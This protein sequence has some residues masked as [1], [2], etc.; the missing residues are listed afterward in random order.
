M[1]KLIL[2]PDK[3]NLKPHK[4]TSKFLIV[5]NV[6]FKCLEDTTSKIS[7]TA[8]ES[9]HSFFQLKMAPCLFTNYK[10]IYKL[11]YKAESLGFCFFNFVLKVALFTYQK[12]LIFFQTDSLLH[13][14]SERNSLLQCLR[15]NTSR[16]ASC[17]HGIQ[18]LQGRRSPALNSPDS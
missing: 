4:I 1:I 17:T 11:I 15:S 16:T 8:S 13:K 18:H 2:L 7:G 3:R 10:L 12:S 6:F 14:R 9:P 5:N